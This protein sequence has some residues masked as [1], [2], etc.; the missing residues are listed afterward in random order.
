MCEFWKRR[1]NRESHKFSSHAMAS[2]PKSWSHRYLKLSVLEKKSTG[3]PRE[4][5]VVI[6]EREKRNTQDTSS[7]LFLWNAIFLLL[8]FVASE[9]AERRRGERKNKIW[10]AVISATFPLARVLNPWADRQRNG[11]P[12]KLMHPSI[13]HLGGKIALKCTSPQNRWLWFLFW[14]YSLVKSSLL[15]KIQYG[16]A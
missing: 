8:V 7:H 16:K 10:A 14:E 4:K 5:R 9:Y 2:I 11:R 6:K 15:L 1:K 12:I 3:K 13:F